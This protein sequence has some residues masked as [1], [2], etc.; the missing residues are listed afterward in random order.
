MKK[1]GKKKINQKYLF[2][3]DMR[4]QTNGIMSKD[5][6][7]KQVSFLNNLQLLEYMD[8]VQ[9]WLLTENHESD[10]THIHFWP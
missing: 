9:P 7:I 8:A 6:Y 5:F 4:L 2:T 3:K 1:K 10:V